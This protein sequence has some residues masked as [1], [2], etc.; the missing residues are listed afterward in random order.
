[1]WVHQ[2]TRCGFGA[3]VIAI[4][5]ATPGA[6]QESNA[7]PVDGCAVSIASVARSGDE[8]QVEFEANFQPDLSKNHIHIWWGEN[9]NVAQVSNNAEP[10]HGVEQGEWHPID[11][12]R[13][14]TTQS[15]ASVAN[16]G[17]ALSLCVSAADRS[18]NILDVSAF[19]CALI[20]DLVE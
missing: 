16:R 7:C 9:Y 20:K 8:L 18:H 6:A 10:T 1:M 19:D 3:A 2:V 15:A 13:S 11:D 5:A 4:F 17:E 14:Y 12:Y